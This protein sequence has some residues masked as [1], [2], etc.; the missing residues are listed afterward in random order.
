MAESKY[1]HV[2]QGKWYRVP[3]KDFDHQCCDCGL[4][5]KINFRIKY[6]PGRKSRWL[7][8]QFFRNG[9]A[10]GGARSR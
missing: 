5:H 4:V 6:T 10:T 2:V 8:M 9:P 7:E 3:M 1:E